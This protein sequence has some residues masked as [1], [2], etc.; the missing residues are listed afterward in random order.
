[1]AAI[2]RVVFLHFYC[3]YLHWA[4]N[5]F[6]IAED[7][8]QGF[9]SK[10]V[11]QSRLSE[12][13]RRVVGVFH[14]RNRNC[15]VRNAIIDDRVHRHGHGVFREHLCDIIQRRIRKMLFS[16][17][18]LFSPCPSLVATLISLLK[19][20]SHSGILK[21]IIKAEENKEKNGHR[22]VW[23]AERKQ[24]AWIN[25]GEGEEKNGTIYA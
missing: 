16:M 21:K 22:Q 13:T 10:N 24:A 15:G 23:G 20:F 18:H 3:R 9:G 8:V 2:L 11:P 5:W 7:F 4:G 1:M 17:G 25:R 6:S 14:V 19:H 12:Q